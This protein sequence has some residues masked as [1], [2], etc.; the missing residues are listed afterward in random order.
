M[1]NFIIVVGEKEAKEKTVDVRDRDHGQ[2]H[3][4]MY[5]Q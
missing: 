3:K 4:K 5:L 1:Y 2:E